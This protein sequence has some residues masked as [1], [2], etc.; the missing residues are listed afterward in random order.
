MKSLA[1]I[2]LRRPKNCF[3]IYPS[4]NVA[5]YLL[6]QIW[7]ATEL[8]I[9]III[10]D[11]MQNDSELVVVCSGSGPYLIHGTRVAITN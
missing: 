6:F 3:R 11:P 8:Q 5:S 10:K 9:R 1:P 2:F 7:A 4:A